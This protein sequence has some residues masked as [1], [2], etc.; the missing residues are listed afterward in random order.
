MALFN[1]YQQAEIKNILQQNFFPTSS[2]DNLEEEKIVV[3]PSPAA[4]S[5]LPES[6]VRNLKE[7]LIYGSFGDGFTSLAWIDREKT[8]LTFDAVATAFYFPPKVFYQK[9]KDCLSASECPI[10][11]EQL[12]CRDDKCLSTRDGKLFLN[13]KSI[14]WPSE[15][16]SR[17]RITISVLE[18]KWLVG[19]IIG[20]TQD[21]KIMVYSFDEK[22]FTPLLGV[23]EVIKPHYTNKKG[24]LSF[25]GI[26][27]DFLVLYLGYDG[28]AFHFKD[29]QR[30]DISSFFDIR[31]ADEGFS[32]KILRVADGSEVFWYLTSNTEW[33]QKFIKL[34]QNNT[35]SIE[36]LADFSKQFFGEWMPK[37]VALSYSGNNGQ[38]RIFKLFLD[39]GPDY[40]L[41]QWSVTDNGFDNSTDR[42]IVSSNL[43]AASARMVSFAKATNVGL[44]LGFG[45]KKILEDWGGKAIFQFS[46]NN[47]DW[48]EVNNGEEI[49]FDDQEGGFLYWRAT[50]KKSENKEYSPFFYN[51]NNLEYYFRTS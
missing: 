40:P 51:F 30:Q 24:F 7:G 36:G 47:R 3:D 2:L 34:W 33:K 41:A 38:G 42:K 45:Q 31:V 29:G 6:E 48:L 14:A 26:D 35:D 15:E 37:K 12:A 27:N 28:L 50:L 16:F 49:I 19:A 32:A 44:N 5:R 39:Y 8:D 18:K 9:V 22:K 10:V 17:A 13:K 11:E 21:E 23:N 46:N 20:D 4:T 25:G 1:F 43:A